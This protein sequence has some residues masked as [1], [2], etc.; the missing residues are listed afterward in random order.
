MH[1]NNG[2]SV[3][4]YIIDSYVPPELSNLFRLSFLTSLPSR[5]K[6]VIE[7]KYEYPVSDTLAK[8]MYSNRF[9]RLKI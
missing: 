3:D 2:D 5:S 8:L 7:D 4:V 9:N 6:I 1:R